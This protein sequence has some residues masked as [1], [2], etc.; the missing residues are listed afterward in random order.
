MWIRSQEKSRLVN[1]NEI[2]IEKEDKIFIIKCNTQ[3]VNIDA[4][5]NIGSYKSKDYCIEI[6]N[7]IQEQFN[8]D[9]SGTFI[10]P[11]E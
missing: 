2:W 4:G 9:D 1:A 8:I 11:E 5:W 6:L 3:S 7:R 10:M